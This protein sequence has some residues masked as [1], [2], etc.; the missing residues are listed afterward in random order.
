MRRQALT[1]HASGKSHKKHFDRKKFL[2]KAKNSEQSETC[3]S[4]SQNNTPIEIEKDDQPTV[5]NQLSIELMLKDS[6]KEKAEIVWGLKSVLSG[7][8]IPIIHVLISVKYYFLMVKLPNHLNL[9]PS[10]L[11]MLSISELLLILEIYCKI[12]CKNLIALLFLLT[13]V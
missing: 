10:N 9:E 11:N 1:S 8:S 5:V 12:I 3:S 7:Y 4:S 13:K 2:F 6:Q